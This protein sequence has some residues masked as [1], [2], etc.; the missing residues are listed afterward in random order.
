MQIICVEISRAK[1]LDA[2]WNMI[3]QVP[4][5]L[6][7]SLH[8]LSPKIGKKEFIFVNGS[9]VK[10]VFA[11]VEN[12][13]AAIKGIKD[14]LNSVYDTPQ[15]LQF[16]TLEGPEAVRRFFHLALGYDSGSGGNGGEFLE[17][18]NDCITLASKN[19]YTG[20]VLNR[21]YRT[22]LL[23]KGKI[24]NGREPDELKR[25][26]KNVSD[27]ITKVFGNLKSTSILAIGSNDLSEAV[28][29]QLI[30]RGAGKI[31]FCHHDPN[32]AQEM[33]D[34][35]G[36]TVVGE[37]KIFDGIVSNEVILRMNRDCSN[38]FSQP[39]LTKTMTKRKNHPLLIINL[40][41]SIEPDSEILKIY[42]LFSYD[43]R[44]L[45]YFGKDS[46]SEI[47]LL[48][49]LLEQEL[50]SFFSW[51][52]SKERYRFGNIIGKSHSME[53]ILELIARIS[54][55]DI[56]VLI[57]GESGTGKE[58]IAKAIHETSPRRDKPFIVVNCGALTETLL[59]SELFG[60][61]RGAF[62]GATYTK[63]GLF[64]EAHRG[65]IFLDEIGDTSQAMQVKL[66]R[67]L[68]EGEIRRVGSNEFIKIDVRLIAATN[69]NLLE[70]VHQGNFRQDLYYR[71]NV[72]E[73]SIPPL[74]D[75]REDILPL[76]EYFIHKY[77]EKMRKKVT[78]LSKET[79]DLLLN[80]H[81]PGNV[82]ELENAIEH[83]VALTIGHIIHPI[84]L[85]A[86]LRKGPF[87][88]I[89]EKPPAKLTLKELERNYILSSLDESS[90]NY[91]LV[92]QQLGIGRTT[93]WRKIKEYGIEKKTS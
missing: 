30:F 3:D 29:S 9:E 34:K 77:A 35:Y 22:A 74:R 88:S 83:A 23:L 65:T 16:N 61:V 10:G 59:E 47:S 78:S 80:Y 7:E 84:D 70:L 82:R 67:V 14:F 66:L 18:V 73:I 62:T 28:V 36:G 8:R 31:S 90:W 46:S 55:T 27:L 1:T 57:E 6:T 51:F 33:A 13:T 11:V 49:N 72:V 86:H 15:S 76:A 52:Y 68:Q 4:I 42:N 44:D 58:L 2:Q 40:D 93:L 19:N 92:A 69:R 5:S 60:H 91:D 79:V 17:R 56:T 89:G 24:K 41:F 54:Q 38:F 75:R 87:E 25:I 53:K 26:G 20:P 12:K 45:K 21:L 32:I 63:K 50:K 64:E 71:L 85:P 39:T 37:D 48:D 43:L 81:W